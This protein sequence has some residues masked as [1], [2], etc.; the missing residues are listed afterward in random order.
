[1]GWMSQASLGTCAQVCQ[2][3]HQASVG[4]LYQK[5]TIASR[6]AFDAL[7]D[8]ASKDARASERLVET[9]LL[10]IGGHPRHRDAP[11]HVIPVVFA[12]MMPGVRT[13]VFYLSQQRLLHSTFFRTLHLFRA[14]T[15]L[16]LFSFVLDSFGELRSIICAFP[17]LSCLKL[18][19][20]TLRAETPST[21]IRSTPIR[22]DRL[23]LGGA[24]HLCS[25][26]HSSSGSLSPWPVRI[27]PTWPSGA[28]PTI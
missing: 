21:P 23:V 27:L 22:L 10:R 1:M 2:A 25:L 15:T 13:L 17:Q 3:W 8:F 6:T 19:V 12:R 26:F 20:G 4:L 5:I 24:W 16:E 9:S 7:V 14:V 28:L 11:V 18:A